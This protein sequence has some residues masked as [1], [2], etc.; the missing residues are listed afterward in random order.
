MIF[1]TLNYSGSVKY[2]IWIDTEFCFAI[3]ITKVQHWYILTFIIK[4]PY[5]VTW[6][7][8]WNPSC[9]DLSLVTGSLQ[10]W[11]AS[12]LA[13]VSARI[14]ATVAPWSIN[15]WKQWCN[16]CLQNIRNHLEMSMP[17]WFN[18]TCISTFISGKSILK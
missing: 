9:I 2:T 1:T 16:K 18:H 7:P 4:M 11:G 8:N 5:Q 12:C 15:A 14:S 13:K 3:L 17:L 10:V 6:L